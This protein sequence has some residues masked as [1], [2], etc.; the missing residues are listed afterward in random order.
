MP[1]NGHIEWQESREP[2]SEYILRKQWMYIHDTVHLS[3]QAAGRDNGVQHVERVLVQPQ[4]HHARRPCY[5]TIFICLRGWK[6]VKVLR[7]LIATG[8][9][10]LEKCRGCNT[11]M[12]IL[13]MSAKHLGNK[14]MPSA[15][16]QDVTGVFSSELTSPM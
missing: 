7:S 2:A 6:I 9:W 8:D 11:A 16:P 1:L 14:T 12:R 5:C 3:R 4:M 10:D 15:S 13:N